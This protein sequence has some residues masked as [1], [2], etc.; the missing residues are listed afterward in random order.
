MDLPH[1]GFL[2]DFDRSC[3]L[4]SSNTNYTS[5][6]AYPGHISQYI[7][8]EVSF[9]AMYGP[10]QQPPFKL[11]VSPFITREKQNS[12]RRRVIVDLS[13]PPNNSVNY[14]VKKHQYLDSI[15]QLQYTSIDHITAALKQVGPGSLFYKINVS[16]AFRHL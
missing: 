6:L 14:R 1:Y 4:L 5:A 3:T 11:H 12:D 7:Q 15:F 9:K 13:W 2:I 10:F 8:E 16:C